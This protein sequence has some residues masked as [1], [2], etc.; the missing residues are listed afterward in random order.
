MTADVLLYENLDV[1]CEVIHLKIGVKFGEVLALEDL[2][3]LCL[4]PNRLP[5][6]LIKCRRI[7]D[8]Q[9]HALLGHLMGGQLHYSIGPSSN[10]S[11]YPEFV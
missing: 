7:V 8:L 3:T 9:S 11:L 4:L 6:L 5:F 1:A 2:E 10:D